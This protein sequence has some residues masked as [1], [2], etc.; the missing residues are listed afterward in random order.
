MQ[1]LRGR[2]RWTICVYTD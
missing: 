1:V 2:I